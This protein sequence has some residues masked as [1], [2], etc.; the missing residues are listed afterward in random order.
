MTAKKQLHKNDFHGTLSK[1]VLMLGNKLT[2][3][4]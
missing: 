1:I 2:M 4:C 3:S